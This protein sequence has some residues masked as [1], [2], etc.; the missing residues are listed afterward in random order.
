MPC[1]H[2][3]EIKHKKNEKKNTLRI[4]VTLELEKSHDALNNTGAER[5]QFFSAGE[6]RTKH[7]NKWQEAVGM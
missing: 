7:A 3:Q 2:M 5:L 4:L 6:A 1:G